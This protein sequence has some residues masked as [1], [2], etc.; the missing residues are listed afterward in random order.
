MLKAEY[1][2]TGVLSHLDIG[3]LNLL[4]ISD[5]NIR[6]FLERPFRSNTD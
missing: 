5:F 6:I 3:I 1:F 4:R 2:P